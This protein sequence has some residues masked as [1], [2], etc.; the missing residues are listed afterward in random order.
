M[1]SNRW[2]L[3]CHR[4][5]RVYLFVLFIHSVYLVQFYP[6]KIY[7]VSS[8]PRCFA[9]I[10]VKTLVRKVPEKPK[11]P[12]FSKIFHRKEQ[13]YGLHFSKRSIRFMEYYGPN[14]SQTLPKRQNPRRDSARRNMVCTGRCQK[15]D[16]IET[17][18]SSY[19][20]AREAAAASADKED[21]PR[22]LRLHTD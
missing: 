16:Q 10:L 3:E 9:L 13:N 11:V 20:Q 19:P 12:G 4:L 15:A 14:D 1:K 18:Y 22:S 2:P 8:Y 21:L 17:G 7:K 5:P 6:R